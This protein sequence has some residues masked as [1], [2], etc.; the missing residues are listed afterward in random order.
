M[1]KKKQ[2]TMEKY[3]EIKKLL[4]DN[5]VSSKDLDKYIQTKALRY[6]RYRE[7]IVAT[8]DEIIAFVNGEE[9]ELKKKEEGKENE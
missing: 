8:D 4:E 3:E 9:I 1:A 6:Q 2:F 7:E 5:K